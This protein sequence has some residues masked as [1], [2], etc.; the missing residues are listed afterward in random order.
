MS[1]PRGRPLGFRLS[2][3]SKNQISETRTGQKHSLQTRRKI[4]RSVE[5][6]FQT[7]IG[8]A[9]RKKQSEMWSVMMT[10]KWHKFL[11]SKESEKY[12]KEFSEL[13]SRMCT[14]MHEFNKEN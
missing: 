10:D 1:R 3:E 13:W 5:R 14:D 2:E 8:K 7:P 9:I 12:S 4:A 11:G 6:Y